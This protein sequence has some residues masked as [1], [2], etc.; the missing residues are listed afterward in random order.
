M[1]LKKVQIHTFYKTI[2]IKKQFFAHIY[3]KCAN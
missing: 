3:N 2:L 1:L